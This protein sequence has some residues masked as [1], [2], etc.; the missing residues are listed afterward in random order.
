MFFNFFVLQIVA[1][2]QVMRLLGVTTLF[3]TNAAGGINRSYNVG[4]LMIIK[5]H[6]NF[7][8][9]AGHNPLVGPNMDE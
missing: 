6:I 2:V 7:A 5:D 3:V 1:P 8:G 9:M 4:D